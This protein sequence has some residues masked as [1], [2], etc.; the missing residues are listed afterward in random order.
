MKLS[1]HDKQELSLILVDLDNFKSTNDNH[2]HLVGDKILTET[3][4]ASRQAQRSNRHR[5]ITPIDFRPPFHQA[6]LPSQKIKANCLKYSC[7]FHTILK[8]PYSE[9]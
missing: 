3:A 6:L 7:D 2:G 5:R 1:R 8:L 9:L 4:S